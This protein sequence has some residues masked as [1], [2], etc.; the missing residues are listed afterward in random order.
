[1]APN[2]ILI[3]STFLAHPE[4][5]V[6]CSNLPIT[7][8]NKETFPVGSDFALLEEQIEKHQTPSGKI[9]LFWY[10]VYQRKAK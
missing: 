8:Y 2:G 6:Q 3:I 9:Q 4:N 1:L 7:Q 5:P 10:G